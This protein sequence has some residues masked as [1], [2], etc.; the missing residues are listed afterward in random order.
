M[1]SF[2][3]IK[4]VFIKPL[5]CPRYNDRDW[6]LPKDM[7]KEVIR[8]VINRGNALS[9]VTGREGKGGEGGRT[10][11]FNAAMPTVGDPVKDSS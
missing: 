2:Y 9:K 11:H 8:A 7:Q 10:Q 6:I 4:F 1:Y 5:L 3:F